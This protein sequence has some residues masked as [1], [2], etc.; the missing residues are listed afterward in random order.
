M[1]IASPGREQERLHP[2]G[3]AITHAHDLD[4]HAVLG[5]D[6]G[7]DLLE[8]GPE[9]AF[10]VIGALAFEQPRSELALLHP[11]QAHHF[12][13]IVG[14]ALDERERLQHGVVQMRGDVGALVGTDSFAALG[15]ELVHELPQSGAEDQRDPDEHHGRA[16]HT[17]AQRAPRVDAEEERGK[18]R[19]DARGTGDDPRQRA[20]PRPDE[21]RDRVCGF[22]REAIE[23]RPIGRRRRIVAWARRKQREANHGRAQRPHDH[24]TGPRP[25][26]AHQE[27]HAEHDRRERDRRDR[28]GRPRAHRS[29]VVAAHE[30][31][32]RAVEEYADAAGEGEHEKTAADDV[33]V[34]LQRVAEP[35]GHARD[36]PAVVPANEA[37]TIETHNQM[38]AP[39][40]GAADR[41]IPR[42]RKPGSRAASGFSPIAPSAPE[43]DDAYMNTTPPEAPAP[44]KGPWRF[45]RRERG[46][47]IAGVATGMAD[48]FHI[49]VL[50][51]RV[52][53]V[54]A[55]LAT[56][57]IAVGAYG[58]CWLA[59]PSEREP[60]PLSQLRSRHGDSNA[61]FVVGL[62][63]LGLGALFVLG[64]LSRPF[65]HTRGVGWALVLIAAGLAVL[66]LRHPDHDDIDPP[67]WPP[68]PPTPP[69]GTPLASET[70]A[71]TEAPRPRPRPTHPTRSTT[72]PR[73]MPK[74][75]P[76]RPTQLRLRGRRIR[77]GRR[78][79]LHRRRQLPQ[80]GRDR[81]GGSRA[82][83]GE[84][85]SSRRSR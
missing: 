85:R 73:P 10:H 71:T 67:P 48:A 83:R 59:F 28:V 66:F 16:D 44:P 57:G 31:P 5:L 11:R 55:A 32:G 75:P 33:G 20:P 41:D 15:D 19:G 24:V 50:V 39:H 45:V 29:G 18:P 60:S 1:A 80:V 47:M 27:E 72:L 4:R 53:W 61:G 51:I 34:D 6:F 84:G 76:R 63:L 25:D 79:P 3:R 23:E 43:A 12:A 70:P 30:E 69:F 40:G 46:R 21:H 81:R 26:R 2:R 64:R 82:G 77:R 74:R 13:G 22:G 14:A 54:V 42:A 58:I 49:D 68:T 52:L 17:T 38:I 8:R 56:F 7:R 37:V 9:R 62:V 78:R 36:D 35:D 65:D